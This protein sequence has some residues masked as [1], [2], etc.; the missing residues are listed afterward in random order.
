[1]V[2]DNL[3]SG[4]LRYIIERRVQPGARLP[5]IAELSR[6]LGVSVS[7]V[8]EELEVARMLG[9]VV[10][11]PRIG[12]QVQEF[13][14]APAATL[15]VL[16]ALGL[17]GAFFHQFAR[18]RNGVEL[19][20]WYDAVCQLLPDDIEHL[21]CLVTAAYKKLNHIPVIVPFEEHRDLH[22]TFFKRLDNPFVQ[23]ILQAYWVAY[24]A[25][26]LALYAELSYHREVWAYHER[27]VECVARQDYEAGWR[28][29]K[30]HM[31]LLRHMPG[32]AQP[33]QSEPDTRPP[34]LYRLF[35]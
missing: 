23:G 22:L 18:L 13:T 2:P 28:A 11:K 34:P 12:T 33:V 20:F 8:R 24:K 10:I 5:T 6:E 14:F 16:Y 30:D 4:V 15:S 7:K 31:D 19:S 9:L 25:F 32:P 26:G 35:E 27:M 3:N 17:D 29:L 1:M 21:R